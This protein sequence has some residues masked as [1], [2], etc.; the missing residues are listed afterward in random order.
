[1]R[2]AQETEVLKGKSGGTLYTNAT[3]KISYGEMA[4]RDGQKFAVI[5]TER[6]KITIRVQCDRIQAGKV[7]QDLV[8]NQ[9]HVEP[10]G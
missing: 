1:M 5:E 9:R 4:F 3:R 8:V 10:P 7:G 2:M 6:R